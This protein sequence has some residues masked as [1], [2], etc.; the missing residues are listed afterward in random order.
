[1]FAEDINK[2]PSVT[3]KRCREDR[4]SV[5]LWLCPPASCE[6]LC[7]CVLDLTSHST[8][9]VSY[10]SVDISSPCPEA[11][12]FALPATAP[13]TVSLLT[14]VPSLPGG[15]LLGHSEK[16]HLPA[17]VRTPHLPHSLTPALIALSSL[18]LNL[19]TKSLFYC[20]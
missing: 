14:T 3:S 1:M 20:V 9:P 4:D 7:I 2:Q 17:S 11:S 15:H 8:A 12:A 10:C 16:G 19:E 6:L 5:V 18:H 13:C